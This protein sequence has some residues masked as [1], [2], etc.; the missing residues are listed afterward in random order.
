M[1]AKRLTTPRKTTNLSAALAELSVRAAGFPASLFT[2]TPPTLFPCPSP[3]PLGRCGDRAVTD[4][5]GLCRAASRPRAS[6]QKWLPPDEI[7]PVEA[8][9]QQ[10]GGTCSGDPLP[11]GEVHHPRHTLL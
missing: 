7:H 8:I 10:R 1:S 5:H 9:S 6:H 4:R 11:L 2:V 3:D